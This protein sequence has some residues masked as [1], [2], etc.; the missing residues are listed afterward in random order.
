MHNKTPNKGRRVPSSSPSRTLTVR[1]RSD[2]PPVAVSGAGVLAI[3]ATVVALFAFYA[4]GYNRFVPILDHA[5]L[6]FHEAGHVFFSVLGSSM[7]L[8]G[9]TLGQLVFPAVV[10]VSFY[11]KGEFIQTA[12]G[13]L[14]LCQNVLNIARYAADARA[15][16]LPLVGGG[17]HDWFNILYRWD[18]LTADK[19]FAGTITSLAWIGMILTAVWIARRWRQTKN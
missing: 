8:Y 3:V 7:G 10:A 19:T 17:D 1:H 11:R 13:V 6:A 18:A 16:Q 9:G 12:F 5:N 4:G 14:W 15:Q 2:E